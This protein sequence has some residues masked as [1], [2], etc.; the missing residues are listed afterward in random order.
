MRLLLVLAKQ[1]PLTVIKKIINK[2]IE[3]I[4]MLSSTITTLTVLLIVIFLFKEGISVFKES[5]L[6]GENVIV[7]SNQNNV[8][9]LTAVDLKK[10][11]DQEITNW[12]MVG[13]KNDSILLFTFNDL[14]NYFSEEELGP[15]F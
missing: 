10:I 11:F 14:S 15:E 2:T 3:G 12:K 1:L 9:H 13:G 8:S 7:L 6:E 4:L 5:P